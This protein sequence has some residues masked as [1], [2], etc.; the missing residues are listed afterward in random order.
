VRL[1]PL[2]KSQDPRRNL[3]APLSV[4]VLEMAVHLAFC[5]LCGSSVTLVIQLLA[6]AESHLQLDTGVFEIQGEGNKCVA[7]PFDVAQQ[8]HDLFFVHEQLAFTQRIAIEDVALFVGADVHADDEHLTVNDLTE[9]VL[10]IDRTASQA[11]DLG[12]HQRDSALKGLVHEIVVTRFAVKCDYLCSRLIHKT[13]LL[14]WNLQYNNKPKLLRSQ[15]TLGLQGG[16]YQYIVGTHLYI[17]YKKGAKKV[18]KI[19]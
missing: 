8:T 6:A 14:F 19:K 4:L 2:N 3:Y 18:E 12:T 7:I 15:V 17:V 1:C 11:L 10:E 13:D 5:V 16:K 9:R